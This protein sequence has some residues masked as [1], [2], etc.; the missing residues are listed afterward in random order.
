M[1]RLKF[2]QGCK[3]SEVTTCDSINGTN[4]WN[5]IYVLSLVNFLLLMWV[6]LYLEHR[7]SELR[8]HLAEIFLEDYKMSFPS[9]LNNFR[10]NSILFNIRITAPAWS[11]VDL[12]ETL[13][14]ALYYE[15]MSIF[16]A[17]CVQWNNGSWPL[18]HSV[19][20]CLFIE[21]LNPLILRSIN[22]Q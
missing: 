10:Y 3:T 2:I 6:P 14:L 18:I 17:S 15:V 12:L 19:K 1:K 22:D 20:S 7:Y 11:L 16:V 8:H 13:F 9:L 21:E 4:V 5:L